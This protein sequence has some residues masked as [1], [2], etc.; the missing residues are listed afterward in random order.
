MVNDFNS[1]ASPSPIKCRRPRQKSSEPTCLKDKA[2]RLNAKK[3][4]LI[5]IKKKIIQLQSKLA[6]FQK[7]KD[8]TYKDKG[9]SMMST[10]SDGNKTS[11]RTKFSSNEPGGLSSPS[12]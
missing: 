12:P 6:I 7:L 2:S 1:N 5:D 10:N 3:G 4:D 9:S 11:N 8:A